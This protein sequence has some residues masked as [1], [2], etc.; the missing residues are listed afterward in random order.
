MP[1]KNPFDLLIQPGIDENTKDDT[2]QAA[3][4]ILMRQTWI[5]ELCY[6]K[7]VFFFHCGVHWSVSI[8]YL[9]VNLPVY[10]KSLIHMMT[11]AGGQSC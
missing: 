4:S 7:D 11:G 8:V 5:S 10:L 1:M 6:R 2:L 9:S 3:L